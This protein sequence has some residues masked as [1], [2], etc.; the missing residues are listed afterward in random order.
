MGQ[1]RRTG[2]VQGRVTI[3]AAVVLAVSAVGTSWSSAAVVIDYISDISASGIWQR[4]D[5]DGISQTFTA[6]AD[7]LVDGSLLL[8]KSPTFATPWV[9]NFRFQLR[10]GTPGNFD[11]SSGNIVFQSP[12]IQ[13]DDV[14]S[15][16]THF[17][18]DLREL[19]LSDHGFTTMPLTV[20]QTYTL[21]VIDPLGA[22]GTRT[23]GY[24]TFQPSV[25]GGGAEW[26][27]N[28]SYA[29]TFWADNTPYEDMAFKVVMTPEPGATAAWVAVLSLAASAR[30]R[31][32]SSGAQRRARS[33]T[34]STS[35]C[36]AA[37]SA[38]SSK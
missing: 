10:A 36:A 15:V 17:G 3:V 4:S 30:H 7:T 26:G 25:Y 21:A 27:H 23:F 29:N 24:V 6:T 38:T 5:L 18:Q 32:R 19:K 8:A 9:A 13:I 31:R 1:E 2:A 34:L 22:A 16:G 28:R 11:G 37:A 35:C 20:G 14:P 33:D 12:P